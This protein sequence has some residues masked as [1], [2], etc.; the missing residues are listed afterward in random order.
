MVSHAPMVAAARAVSVAG[1]PETLIAA[2]TEKVA[3]AAHR[4]ASAGLR[5]SV[6]EDGV[7][8]R[9]RERTHLRTS[10]S[11]ATTLLASSVQWSQGGVQSSAPV[12][13]RLPPEAEIRVCGSAFV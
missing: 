1:L 6:A 12:G 10:P 11:C 13:E 3:V 8:Q 4:L 7:P 5:P 9:V 2:S